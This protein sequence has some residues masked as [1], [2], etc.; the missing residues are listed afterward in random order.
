MLKPPDFLNIVFHD[1]HTKGND[2]GLCAGF[3]RGE[4]RESALVEHVMEWLPEFALT[5]D[6]LQSISYHN[7]QRMVRR[8]ANSVYKTEKYGNRGEFGEVLLHIAIRQ[9]FTTIPA[10]SKIYYKSAVN[11]TVKGFDAVHVVDTGDELELWIGETKFYNDVGRAIRDVCDEIIDHL[12]TDYLRNEFLLITNK[13]DSS[14]PHAENLKKLIDENTSLD[15]IFS[16]AT[17]PILLT[18]DSDI[19]KDSNI[20]DQ[21]YLDDIKIE[22]TSAYTKLRKRLEDKHLET[23]GSSLEITVHILLFPL[24]DKAALTTALNQRL[25]ELQG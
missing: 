3:E 16:K 24:K 9:I 2:V 23:Y 15:E 5:Y 7:A 6:E 8:A 20:S 21:K 11:E 12:N 4:W 25:K 1:I 14:W 17:I 13:I 19:V 10:V 22:L 18:Y